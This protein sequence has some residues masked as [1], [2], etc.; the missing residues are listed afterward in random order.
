MSWTGKLAELFV[1]VF[2]H[3]RTGQGLAGIHAKLTE[4]GG[5][6]AKVLAI[7]VSI[8]GGAAVAGAAKFLYDA[9]Q[10]ASDLGETMSKTKEVFGDSTG[11][12]NA[13]ADEMATKFGAVKRTILDAASMFGLVLQGAGMSADAS[14]QL[15]IQ[16]ARLADDAS[17]FYNVPLDVALEKIRAG[18]RA[19]P[20]PCGRSA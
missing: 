11:K 15:S 14:A 16:L 18:S 8:V 5:R 13:F 9:T 20:S 6:A 4:W 17:S 12:I 10:K 3:D 19:R 7:P 2:T 1:E